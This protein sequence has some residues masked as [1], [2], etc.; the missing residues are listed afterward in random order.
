ML[1][2]YFMGNLEDFLRKNST[3]IGDRFIV[4]IKNDLK[5][6]GL[7]ISIRNLNSNVSKNFI[8]KDPVDISVFLQDPY[9]PKAKWITAEW[10]DDMINDFDNT[11]RNDKILK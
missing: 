5:D 6:K 7:E 8:I 4:Q 11:K 1:I 10:R 9:S 3:T 2:L